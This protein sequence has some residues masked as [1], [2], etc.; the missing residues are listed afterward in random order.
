MPQTAVADLVEAAWQHV[1]EEAAHEF[2]AAQAAGSL[3]TGLA[4]L[5]LDG[6]GLVV[7]AGN[8][9][10]GESDAKDVTGKVVE[11]GLCTGAP[12]GNVEDPARAP[13]GIG[14]VELGAFSAQQRPE[15]AAHQLGQSL[16]GHQE[17]TA[18]RMPG[19]GVLRDAAA[20]DQTMNVWVQTPTPTIP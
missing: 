15:L 14:N 20:T 7:E 3:P 19:A 12:S 11:H 5:V 17:F 6:D 10:V 2:V 18:R 13:H 9:R 1:L 8:P 16:D 4:F